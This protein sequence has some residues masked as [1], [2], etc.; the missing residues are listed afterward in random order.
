MLAA[1][2]ASV[3]NL[4]S[5]VELFPPSPKSPSISA[6]DIKDLAGLCAELYGTTARPS[7]ASPTSIDD[8]TDI[9][10][11]PEA[12]L[13]R[14]WNEELE[15]ERELERQF[16][17]VVMRRQA[18]IEHSVRLEIEGAIKEQ[19]AAE[20]E[21]LRTS[22]SEFKSFLHGEIGILSTLS[23]R[24]SA[25]HVATAEL[26]ALISAMIHVLGE[27]TPYIAPRQF[28]TESD[29]GE[30][31]EK[32]L[33]A[34]HSISK[35]PLLDRGDIRLAMQEVSGRFDEVTAKHHAEIVA[36]LSTA[37]L[38]SAT[39]G[40]YSPT[41]IHHSTSTTIEKL[42]SS[43]KAAEK[44]A[45]RRLASPASQASDLSSSH[46]AALSRLEELLQS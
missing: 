36:S 44:N 43:A 46:I 31:D 4:K 38:F 40:L 12:E 15:K 26:V 19:K 37:K 32:L 14:I 39:V 3:E 10:I 22:M 17:E 18:F 28:E 20:L 5:L 35:A 13:R 9:E 34:L 29:S 25:S 16:E 8:P 33:E 7:A 30:R 2:T 24:L 27:E 1:S 45:K 23:S 42:I 41:S 6:A 21:A 11:L